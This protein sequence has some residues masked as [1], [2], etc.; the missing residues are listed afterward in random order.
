MILGNC[1]ALDENKR[2]I[3]ASKTEESRFEK[4]PRDLKQ[5]RIGKGNQQTDSAEYARQARRSFLEQRPAV[6]GDQVQQAGDQE[7]Q[8]K[9]DSCEAHS[10]KR[11]DEQRRQKKI[12]NRRAPEFDDACRDD[13]KDGRL[14]N[15][16][17]IHHLR[18][19]TVLN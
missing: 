12:P 16:K 11:T 13:A 4:Q 8:Q 5:S 14:E 7:N 10:S 17:R 9:V 6:L 1:A 15:I 3:S 18:Q 2:R 19:S